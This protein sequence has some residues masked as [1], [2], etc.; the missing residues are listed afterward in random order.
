MMLLKRL[1]EKK[2]K[3]FVG[4]FY[5]GRRLTGQEYSQASKAE[6]RSKAGRADI[7]MAGW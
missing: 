1:G 6:Q 5:L 2:K 7:D 4:S 3:N